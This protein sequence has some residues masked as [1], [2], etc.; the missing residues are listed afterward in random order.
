MMLG[1]TIDDLDK[2]GNAIH[3]AYKYVSTPDDKEGLLQAQQFLQ[4]LWAEGYFD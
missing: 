3:N 2:M 4:G 1:Y